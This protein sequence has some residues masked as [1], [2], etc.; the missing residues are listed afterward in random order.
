[1]TPSATFSFTKLVVHD[2]EKMSR[3]YTEV[4]GLHAVNRVQGE[5]IAGEEIDEIMMAADPNAQWSSLVLLRY[6]ERGPSPSGELILGFL[7]EDRPALLERVRTAGGRVHA[8]LEAMPHLGL[9]V[10]F[11]TDPEGHLAEVVQLKAP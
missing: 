4:Y 9:D 6:L 5:S 2:V 11:V 10:A 7:T 3:F 8:D 1:M